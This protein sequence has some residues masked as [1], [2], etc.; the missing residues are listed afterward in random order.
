MF[1]G[2]KSP[3][4]LPF[5]T[6]KYKKMLLFSKKGLQHFAISKKNLNFA[7][8][9]CSQNITFKEKNSVYTL[10]IAGNRR[11][12]KAI[13]RLATRVC[14]VPNGYKNKLLNIVLIIQG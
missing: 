7:P 3:I 2:E 4:N 10:R 12:V 6:L 14:R 11:L 9:S 1:Q 13:R 5:F 8:N